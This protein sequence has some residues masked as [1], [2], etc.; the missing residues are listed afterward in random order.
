MFTVVW[1]LVA[2]PKAW[3]QAPDWQAVAGISGPVGNGSQIKAATTDASGNVYMVGTFAGKAGFGSITLTSERNS[4]FVA[5]WSPAAGRFLWVQQAQ[6]FLDNEATAITLNGNDIYIAGQF[7]S[8]TITFGS[9]VLSSTSVDYTTDGFV[10]KLTEQGGTARFVWAERIGG[11]RGQYITAVACVGSSVYVAG[12]TNGDKAQFGAFTFRNASSDTYTTD[13]FVAKLTDAGTTASFTWV[14]YLSGSD[15]DQADALV[16]EGNS[17]YFAVTS[18][19]PTLAIGN[20]VFSSAGGSDVF[21]VRLTDTGTTSNVSWTQQ[22]GGTGVDRARA[23]AL[24]GANLYLAGSSSSFQLP[25]GSSSSSPAGSYD[26]MV[27]K[28]TQAGA[29]V[30]IARGGGAGEES[31]YALAVSGSNVYVAG[32]LASTTARFGT[33]SLARTGAHSSMGTELFVARLTDAGATGDFTWA[34]KADGSGSSN[35]AYAV[36]VS[37]ANVYVAGQIEAFN[38]FG[39]LPVS[40]GGG[41]RRGFLAL[42][43]DAT[44]TTDTKTLLSEVSL[45]PNP[46]RTSVTMQLPLI[47]KATPVVFKLLN[48]VGQ[49][50]RTRALTLTNGLRPELHLAG[51]AAGHYTLLLE[52]DGQWAA[53]SLIVY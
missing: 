51:L 14:Q 34:R 49:V 23:L 31:A 41:T 10:A 52:A 21:V 9:I 19:S 30:W 36:A 6:G 8:S 37:G 7:A 28:L 26:V 24:S 35:Y 17:V 38:T 25:F 22:L 12:H 20:K 47:P 33:T 11:T 15:F 42:L 50:V 40:T 48:T 2:E 32:Y 44:P 18:S 43:A 45:Y 27:A 5:K 29:P 13:A 4:I 53:H 39:S 3:A 16:T 1:A 46:A